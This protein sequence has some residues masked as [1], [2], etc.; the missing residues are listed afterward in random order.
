MQSLIS[1][2]FL[3]W[4]QKKSS[5]E[6]EGFIYLRPYF[7][8]TDGRRVG[9]VDVDEVEEVWRQTEA[10]D[11]VGQLEGVQQSHFGSQLEFQHFN[12]QI[13]IQ[14]GA[15]MRRTVIPY[16]KPILNTS[17]LKIKKMQI[18]T[19]WFFFL[20]VQQFLANCNTEAQIEM[21]DWGC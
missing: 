9:H 10:E 2:A 21:G 12:F 18:E 19:N 20:S 8:L 7:T 3:S 5:K 16:L 11:G 14:I 17:K 4:R 6:Q 1:E 13:E 15:Q